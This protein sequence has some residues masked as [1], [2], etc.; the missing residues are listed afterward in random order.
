[1][2]C[3]ALVLALDLAVL[4]A[5]A[6]LAI[7]ASLVNM[8]SLVF[9]RIQI[10]ALLQRCRATVMAAMITCV[11]YIA[12][13]REQAPDLVP[14]ALVTAIL[15]RVAGVRAENRVRV[16]FVVRAINAAEEITKEAKTGAR[17]KKVV[18]GRT[19]AL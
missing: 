2:T 7:E 8:R 1:M 14:E 19:H 4:V 17:R 18:H 6:L 3:L 13:D 15:A 11:A 16:H 5:G 9:V 12:L 10:C